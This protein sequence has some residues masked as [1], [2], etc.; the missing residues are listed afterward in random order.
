[1]IDKKIT[2]SII[3]FWM[4]FFI[5]LILSLPLFFIKS[6]NNS[7]VLPMVF[8]L[9]LV[10]HI[11]VIFLFR[12]KNIYYV[13]IPTLIITV[14]I[15]LPEIGWGYFSKNLMHGRSLLFFGYF[16]FWLITLLI[17]YLGKKF[18]YHKKNIYFSKPLNTM[19][20][21]DADALMWGLIYIFT[22]IIFL[23][24]LFIFTY[25]I[26]CTFNNGSCYYLFYSDYLFS[27]IEKLPVFITNYLLAIL[28]IVSLIFFTI[29][30]IFKKID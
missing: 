6:I 10:F 24:F 13:S 22:G 27:F 23:I 11:F 8:T 14:F 28:I 30:S 12:S 3:L 29:Y 20:G 15:V 25:I 7:S 19:L 5:P 1:M 4:F 21:N 18:L 26:Y 9:S 17:F 2:P 16:I